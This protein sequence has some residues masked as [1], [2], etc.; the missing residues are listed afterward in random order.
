MAR[1]N[2]SIDYRVFQDFSAQAKGQNKTLFAFANEALDA[3]AK[4]SAEGGTP[5]ELYRLWRTVSLLKQ[6]DVI[7]LPSDFIDELVAREYASDKAGI[8][9]MFRE[10]GSKTVGV[11][12]IVAADLNQL[13]EVAKDFT[14]LLPVKQFKISR[15]QDKDMVEVGVVGAGRRIESTECTLEFLASILNGYGYNV[16]KHEINVGT[17]R[18][19]AKKRSTM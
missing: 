15:Q 19:W 13:E 2:I 1:T 4:I 18:L 7:T 3:V 6:I 5:D 12:K 17:I 9:K 11:L 8:L 16:T 14:T 10:L